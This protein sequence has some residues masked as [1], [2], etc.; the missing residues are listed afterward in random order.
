MIAPTLDTVPGCP[1]RMVF[2][3]CGGVR[4]DGSCELD[5]ALPCPWCGP[6][7]ALR[8]WPT[9]PP[10]S[11]ATLTPPRV[12]TD[13]SVPP[14]DLTA[15]R[16][17]LGLLAPV[18]DALLVGEHHHRPDF[19]PTMLAA[20]IRAAG[21]SPW[22]TLT[23]RDRNRVVLEQELAGLAALGVG[24]V[25]CVTGDGRGQD[26]R[27]E[28]TQVFDLDSTR[29]AHLAAAAGVPT[30]VAVAPAAPPAD[31]RPAALAEKQRAGASMAV[32]NHVGSPAALAAF[33]DA[34]RDAGADLPVIAGVAVYT[35]ERS[36]AVLAAFPG[37]ALDTDAVAAVLAAPDP[38][39]AG[40]DAAVAEAE[41]LLAVPGVV[42]VNLSGLAS[43]DGWRAGA[44]VKAEIAARIGNTSS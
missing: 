8:S 12:L 14:Y 17:V 5:T 25:L 43:A 38:R 31:L 28:V 1:K 26:V 10:T 3:P 4:S 30:A 19:P 11:P 40:I 15:L 44:E 23:C 13:L 20:E 32:A 39:A 22:I 18:S 35:D 7:A 27:P 6:D 33:L 36:A 2:G 41:A 29:L 42:G 16:E 37:L 9:R 21:G 34:A 24:G